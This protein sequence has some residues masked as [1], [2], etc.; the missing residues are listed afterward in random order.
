VQEVWTT[1]PPW[2]SSAAYSSAFPEPPSSLLIFGGGGKFF[3]FVRLH[4]PAS[5]CWATLCRY[6]RITVLVEVRL[7]GANQW[8][9]LEEFRDHGAAFNDD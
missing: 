6:S 9:E 1:L 3:F 7:L 8:W 5:T 2:P 4:G